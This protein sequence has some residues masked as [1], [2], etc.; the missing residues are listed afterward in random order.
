MM[1]LEKWTLPMDTVVQLTLAL[2]ATLHRR[3]CR[4][5][6]A[7]GRSASWIIDQALRRHIEA[8]EAAEEGDPLAR[9]GA[10][11]GRP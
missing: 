3:L 4:L 1:L 6:D 5:A 10:D 7:S 9:R 11:A 8:E 2:D